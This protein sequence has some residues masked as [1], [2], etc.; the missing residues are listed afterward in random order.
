[1]L[2]SESVYIHD[3]CNLGFP[4]FQQVKHK[5]S[6]HHKHHVLNLIETNH[7]VTIGVS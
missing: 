5:P 2:Q 6:L 7:L 1:M 3:L 4:E